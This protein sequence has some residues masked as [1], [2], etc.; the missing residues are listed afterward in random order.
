MCY[1]L[2][3]TEDTLLKEPHSNG[4]QIQPKPSPLQNIFTKNSNTVRNS[5]LWG[6]RLMNPYPLKKRIF[7]FFFF[8]LKFVGSKSILTENIK[9]HDPIC[10]TVPVTSVPWLC[11]HNRHR[12]NTFSNHWANISSTL[13]DSHGASYKLWNN[14]LFWK[15]LFLG[16]F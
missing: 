16:W 10:F 9:L 11:P 7:F 12:A 14:K 1:F 8:L 2:L 3:N 4:T 15:V 5:L 13:W 6:S